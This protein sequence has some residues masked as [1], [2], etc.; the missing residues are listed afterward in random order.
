MKMAAPLQHLFAYPVDALLASMPDED[1]P[2]WDV[3]LARQARFAVHN[4]TRSIN[5]V[6][7]EGWNG[8]GE[9][10]V[11][12][13]DYAPPALR[14]AAADCAR[15]IADHFDGVVTRLILAELSAGTVI[16]PHRDSGPLLTLVHRCHLPILTNAGASFTVDNVDHRLQA[17]QVYEFDNTRQ[18]A[19][20][21]TGAERRVHLIC[22]VLPP[23]DQ[24]RAYPKVA[25]SSAK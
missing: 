17:G 4:Q 21:N 9:P 23:A 5:I 25:N 8:E 7:S 6:W 10:D 13:L 12:R 14:K 15:A 11:L 22:N 20:A 2:V 3:F 1:D 18:H 24:R 16:P 19:V